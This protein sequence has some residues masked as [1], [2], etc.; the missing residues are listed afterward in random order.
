LLV[1]GLFFHPIFHIKA[2]FEVSLKTSGPQWRH[3]VLLSVANFC[4]LAA[5]VLDFHFFFFF[6]FFL[7]FSKKKT[8]IQLSI[9]QN[10]CGCFAKTQSL[11]IC[12]QFATQRNQLIV[13]P[14]QIK[15]VYSLMF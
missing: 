8:P 14:S 2:G 9:T 11:S 5:K 3:K 4:Q 13:W 6:F 1:I 7:G 12:I 10:R 15:I